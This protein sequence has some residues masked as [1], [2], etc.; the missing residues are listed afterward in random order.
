MYVHIYMSQKFA[1]I[2]LLKALCLRNINRMGNP[3]KNLP[4][5]HYVQIDRLDTIDIMMKINLIFSLIKCIFEFL[6]II[7]FHYAN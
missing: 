3:T 5:L 1:L 4:L 7:S 2:I 6:T